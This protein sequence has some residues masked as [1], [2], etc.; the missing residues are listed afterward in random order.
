MWPNTWIEKLDLT[1][2]E[3][4]L[5]N[6]FGAGA[7]HIWGSLTP[8]R[9]TWWEAR[10]PPFPADS[11]PGLALAR[12]RGQYKA[13]SF[14]HVKALEWL[15]SNSFGRRRPSETLSDWQKRT[16]GALEEK[17]SLAF[18]SQVGSNDTGAGHNKKKSTGR[19]SQRR[20]GP[21]SLKHQDDALIDE[22]H[23][24]LISGGANTLTA[25]AD[26]VVGRA[27]GHGTD[28]SKCRRLRRRYSERFPD[29]AIGQIDPN[30]SE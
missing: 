1:F 28:E 16:I 29:R 9:L 6:E 17:L 3:Q 27:A 2:D 22:M 5:L 25:A 19:E 14:Q 30:K 8:G 7:P 26:M 23:G 21:P 20:S 15:E 18:G 24:L 10:D 11:K 12:A 13:W 4:E